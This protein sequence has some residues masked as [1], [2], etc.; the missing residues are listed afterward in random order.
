MTPTT[1]IMTDTGR[2]QGPNCSANQPRPG[3]HGGL[4][5]YTTP[6]DGDGYDGVMTFEK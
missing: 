6:P 3:R 1:T 2:D 4:R 5:S